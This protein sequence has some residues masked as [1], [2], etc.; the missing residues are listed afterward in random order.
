MVSLDA[1]KNKNS[2]Y[3]IVLGYHW[4]AFAELEKSPIL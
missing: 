1:P 2:D 4:E 3:Y